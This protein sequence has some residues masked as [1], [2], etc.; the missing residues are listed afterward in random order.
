[1]NAEPPSG[2]GTIHRS[3]TA[4]RPLTDIGQG[5]QSFTTGPGTD[6]AGGQRTAGPPPPS[7]AR[8]RGTRGH[9]SA[10]AAPLPPDPGRAT[11]DAH[12]GHE[13]RSHPAGR[14]R[15]ELLCQGSWPRRRS[16]RSP[17]AMVAPD[18]S[19][20]GRSRQRRRQRSAAE[21]AEPA[22]LAGGEPSERSNA[23]SS[24]RQETGV[25]AYDILIPL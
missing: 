5:P 21:P 8:A 25:S 14:T 23:R 20:S 11:A 1:M 13:S 7:P 16:A 15:S 18:G 4:T 24:G 19:G 3:H 10:Q 12:G 17:P 22:V 6:T 2:T 9:G